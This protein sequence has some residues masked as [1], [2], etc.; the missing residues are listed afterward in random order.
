MNMTTSDLMKASLVLCAYFGFMGIA[1][2]S[3]AS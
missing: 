2:F 3:V 1:I